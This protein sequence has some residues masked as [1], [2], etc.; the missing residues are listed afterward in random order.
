[1]VFSGKGKGMQCICYVTLLL[2]EGS[3]FS[4]EKKKK[5]INIVEGDSELVT[6]IL[7][8]LQQG[9][10][11]EKI[12]HSWRTATLIQEVG[13]L[14]QQIQYLLPG[15]IKRKGNTT[16]D[17]L[18]NW[19]CQH[20]DRYIECNPTEAIWNVELHS[21]QVIVNKDLQPP[22]GVPTCQTTHHN[23]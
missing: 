17:Y 18:A 5:H 21:L 19:A 15:H 12:T 11:W 10:P 9:I 22:I 23:R 1:M 7:R 6:N 2:I 4:V 13:Q 8:K 3:I 20:P 14:I 16:T